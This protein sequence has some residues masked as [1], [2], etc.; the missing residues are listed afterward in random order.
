VTMRTFRPLVIAALSLVLFAACARKEKTSEGKELS[1]NPLTAINQISEAAKKAADAAKEASEMKPVDPVSFNALIPLLPAAPSG[2]T[3]E[4]PR[5]ETTSAMGF[6][7]SEAERR[8]TKG[9]Q[10]LHVKLVDGAY[11]SFI[12]AGVTMAAQFSHE[13][14]EGYEKGVTIDGNPGV[15]KWSKSSK[16][17]ELTVVV[18]KRFLVTIEAS[19]VESGYVRSIYGTVDVAKLA[20]LK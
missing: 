12:Y 9:D 2:F 17:G 5:G 4:E 10:S 14:T 3:A 11:N 1:K 15:E 19:P 13:S 16:Q 20:A 7:I 8:Y 18:G 6:K